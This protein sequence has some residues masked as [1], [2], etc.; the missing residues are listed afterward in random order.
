MKF[1]FKQITVL[2][3]KYWILTKCRMYQILCRIFAGILFHLREIISTVERHV[4]KQVHNRG[5]IVVVTINVVCH[6][7]NVISIV[8]TVDV[9][10]LGLVYWRVNNICIVEVLRCCILVSRVPSSVVNWTDEPRLVTE[11]TADAQKIWWYTWTVYC[12]AHERRLVLLHFLH[13]KSLSDMFMV[14]VR[15][16]CC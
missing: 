16:S 5:L 2:R 12:D 6:C 9:C 10:I 4:G 1:S 7:K 15:A 3:W 13:N 8:I 11:L 14:S